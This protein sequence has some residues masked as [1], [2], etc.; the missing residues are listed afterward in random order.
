[1]LRLNPANGKM[2]TVVRRLVSPT[3]LAV[4]TNGDLYVA[5]LFPA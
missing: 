2:R 3:G 4:D 5:Q 1:M